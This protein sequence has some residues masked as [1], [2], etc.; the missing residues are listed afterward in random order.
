M[1]IFKANKYYLFSSANEK[2]FRNQKCTMRIIHLTRS[3]NT[4]MLKM[5]V[6]YLI[7]K[8]HIIVTALGLPWHC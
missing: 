8:H 7:L 2:V 4:N 3:L 1:N 5:F 6:Y